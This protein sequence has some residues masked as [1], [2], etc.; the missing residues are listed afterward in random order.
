MRPEPLEPKFLEKVWGATDLSPW[1]PSTRTKIGEVA[2]PSG[3]LLVKFIFTTERLSIQVHPGGPGGKTEMW[4]VLR[5]DPGAVIGLGLRER[6]SR[7][8]L[9]EAALSG[10][11]ERL[12]NW[13]PVRPGDTFFT[14][15][16]AIHAI[17]AGIVLC[18]IQQNCDVTYRLYD[19]GR[20]RELHLEQAIAVADPGP[21]PGK[22]I[23]GGETLVSCEHFVTDLLCWEGES[24]YK[25]DP[26]RFQLLVVVEG[27]GALDRQSF[28][29]GEVWRVPAGTPPVSCRGPARVLRTYVP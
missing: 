6:V 10:E 7:E 29:A 16:G 24:S 18:E 8:R 3:P 21:H 9:R 22:S 20:P 14:P 5:A 15:P 25:A 28:R 1:F 26:S 11:I 17:G 12:V 27:S 4:Y 19:Y 23:S 2:F 13:I